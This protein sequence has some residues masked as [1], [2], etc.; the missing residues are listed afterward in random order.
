MPKFHAVACHACEAFQVQQ[1]KK[2]ERFTCAACGAKQSVRRV[3]AI[4][5]KAKDGATAWNAFLQ[6]AKKPDFLDCKR[7][8]EPFVTA[9]PD[10][11]AKRQ[12]RAV[13]KAEAK[14][15]LEDLPPRGAPSK[16]PPAKAA[17]S[18]AVNRRR[19]AEPGRSQRISGGRM[20]GSLDHAAACGTQV[21][22]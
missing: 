13:A 14:D 11:P 17:G 16:R 20:P 22:H 21:A 3:Y 18:D 2:V 7:V 10:A 9:L 5:G 12:K 8:D 15:G 4:S 1:V 6:D 19:A